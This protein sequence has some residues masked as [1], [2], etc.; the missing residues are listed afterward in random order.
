MSAFRAG[1][2]VR[3]VSGETPRVVLGVDAESGDV[4]FAIETTIVCMAAAHLELLRRPLQ[5]GD[6]V[7]HPDGRLVMGISAAW[8]YPPCDGW[9][10]AD[11]TPIEP[12]SPTASDHP[13]TECGLRWRT[14]LGAFSV[15]GV[16]GRQC[17]KGCHN[18]AAE[19]TRLMRKMSGV[20]RIPCP[21]GG[22]ETEDGKEGRHKPTCAKVVAEHAAMMQQSPGTTPPNGHIS[23]TGLDI[24]IHTAGYASSDGK[25]QNNKPLTIDFV[26]S[27]CG[28]IDYG[29]SV[30]MPGEMAGFV[31][32]WDDFEA[33]YLE[34]KRL[35][36]G[37]TT[38]AR[39]LFETDPDVLA[40][41][42]LRSE[43]D[44]SS[45][46]DDVM[47]R[48]W[49]RGESGAVPE[50][51]WYVRAVTRAKQMAGKLGER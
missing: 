5:P 8:A 19:R 48:C 34:I 44:V 51:A 11:G 24:K 17:S 39:Q 41:V 29:V 3:R 22:F 42:A 50:T 28:K 7:K 6:K 32:D 49:D 9:I 2:V 38:L 16:E 1:D 20:S 4:R 25:S 40:L 35:V 13:C 18:L 27:K 33:A 36:G 43:N 12:A 10:H 21:C 30:R 46:R 15:V 23:I 47:R 31:L 14:D 26:G 45:K 37:S